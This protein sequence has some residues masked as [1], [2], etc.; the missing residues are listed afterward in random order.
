LNYSLP[1][2]VKGFAQIPKALDD[3]EIMI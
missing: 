1:Q 3:E 2:Q